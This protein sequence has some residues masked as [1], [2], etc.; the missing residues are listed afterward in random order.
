MD[1]SNAFR[2]PVAERELLAAL[3]HEIRS[4]LNGVVGMA[5]LLR[6][7]PLNDEQARYVQSLQH[8][9]DTLMVLAND[10]LDYS[11]IEAGQL[12]LEQVAFDVHD[13]IGATMGVMEHQART[14]GLQWHVHG[15]NDLPRCANGDP[16][17]LKQVLLNLLGNAIKFTDHGHV[18]LHCQATPTTDGWWLELAVADS[19]C[20]LTREQQNNLF[21]PYHQAHSA[22][23]RERGGTGLGLVISQRLCQAMGGGLMVRSRPGQGSVFTA[24]MRLAHYQPSADL[25]VCPSGKAT[26]PANWR[27]LVVD[28]ETV[29]REYMGAWLG[30]QG[31]EVACAASGQAALD[32]MQRAPFDL[33]LMDM[34]MPGLTGPDTAAR[35]R[36]LLKGR[37]THTLIVGL[38]GSLD[39]DTRRL[40][41]QQGADHL[42]PK[43]LDW[44]ALW[45]WVERQR[46]SQTFNSASEDQPPHTA[47]V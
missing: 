19:G 17:R 14:K 44:H 47:T 16:T 12:A 46:Q 38:S 9:S 6:H 24:C 39:G 5:C 30:R 7:T 1:S 41:L 31:L 23:A 37:A 18:E 43:P 22:V 11:K 27:V 21:Q 26:P 3:T 13:T 10:M 20:G 32:W 40:Y 25:P 8:C 28:D 15:L 4:T 2:S 34:H 35:M 33:V 45:T 42:L 36:A 29:N